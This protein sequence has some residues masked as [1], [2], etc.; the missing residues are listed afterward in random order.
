MWIRKLPLLLTFM[1]AP[2]LADV[3]TAGCLR[4]HGERDFN[5]EVCA[6]TAPHTKAEV[7][8]ASKK[9]HERNSPRLKELQAACEVR[10]QRVYAGDQERLRTDRQKAQALL[11]R[12][13]QDAIANPAAGP[14]C[15]AYAR[16]F[17]V[18]GPGVDIDVQM[19]GEVR[20]SPGEP[21]RWGP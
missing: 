15:Y 7:Q 11:E 8:A 9:W 18:G 17:A 2:A 12:F 16:D 21:V 20:D 10:L 19:I 4:G 3:L 5:A 6:I 13:K 1:T 14:D